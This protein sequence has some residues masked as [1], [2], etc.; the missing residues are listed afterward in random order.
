MKNQPSLLREILDRPG[1]E[2]NFNQLLEEIELLRKLG[3]KS[4]GLLSELIRRLDS[5]PGDS[6][7]YIYMEN[8]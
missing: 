7:I 5:M 4:A 6:S 2:I 1:Q 3:V 8:N